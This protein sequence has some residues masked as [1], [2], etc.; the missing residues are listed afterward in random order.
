MT[1]HRRLVIAVSALAMVLVVAG[2][3][4]LLV[5]RAFLV[6]RLDAQLA[7]TRKGRYDETQDVCRWREC[8]RR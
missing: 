3:G 7:A 5:Q 8:P 4:V 2:L 6:G 1:L